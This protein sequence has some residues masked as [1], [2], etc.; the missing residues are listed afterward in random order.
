MNTRHQDLTW[1]TQSLGYVHQ[2][3]SL[4]LLQSSDYNLITICNP[5]QLNTAARTNFVSQYYEKY[6]TLSPFIQVL[7]HFRV[8]T[9]RPYVGHNMSATM[10]AIAQIFFFRPMPQTPLFMKYV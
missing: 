1:F 8:I 2:T 9:C 10:S 5:L 7:N 6:P 3:A 4:I